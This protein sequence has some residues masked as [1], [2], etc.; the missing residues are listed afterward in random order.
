M[1]DTMKI[2]VAIVGATVLIFLL[3]AVFGGCASE[4]DG[5]MVRKDTENRLENCECICK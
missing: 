4:Q 5:N 3:C 1:E 2:V